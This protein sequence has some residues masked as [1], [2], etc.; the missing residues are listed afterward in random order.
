MKGKKPKTSKC[1]E[2]F[3]LK[4]GALRAG[5]RMSR[6]IRDS[7]GPDGISPATGLWGGRAGPVSGPGVPGARPLSVASALGFFRPPGF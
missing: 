4:N 3:D 1:N 6:P 7:L 5:G 2:L